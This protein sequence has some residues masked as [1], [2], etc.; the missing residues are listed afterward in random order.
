MHSAQLAFQKSLISF[1]VY[2]KM[3]EKN[4]VVSTRILSSSSICEPP[5]ARRWEFLGSGCLS[6]GKKCVCSKWSEWS[7]QNIRI[8][9]NEASVR[10]W[11]SGLRR[12]KDPVIS[13]LVEVHILGKISSRCFTNKN[14]RLE[15]YVK[16]KNHDWWSPE[17]CLSQRALMPLPGYW[18]HSQS[19]VGSSLSHHLA[20]NMWKV[21]QSIR[22]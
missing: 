6:G 13:K 22:F 9:C 21:R 17:L 19:G 20:A 14:W 10:S 12:G 18:P 1:I 2:L 16:N 8:Q 4:T 11:F 15:S 5:T 3:Q 7:E